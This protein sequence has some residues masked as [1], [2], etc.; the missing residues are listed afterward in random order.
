MPGNCSRSSRPPP[1]LDPVESDPVEAVEHD[2]VPAEAG[3]VGELDAEELLAGDR[4]L[5]G[6]GEFL[7]EVVWETTVPGTVSLGGTVNRYAAITM[8]VL[9]GVT[10]PLGMTSMTVPVGSAPRAHSSSGTRPSARSC[11]STAFSGWPTKSAALTSTLFD[12][13]F[14]DPATRPDCAGAARAPEWPAGAVVSKPAT[15]QPAT[16]IAAAVATAPAA[17]AKRLRGLNFLTCG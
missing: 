1:E 3:L 2:P 15:S 10:G 12:V 6:L 8:I 16:P 5:L 7:G 11:A 14:W 13:G 17:I 4:E 9:P